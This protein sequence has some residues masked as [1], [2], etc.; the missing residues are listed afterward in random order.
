M[1]T[2]HKTKT[3]QRHWQRYTR[4]KTKT[5]QRHWQRYT[6][7]KTQDKQNTTQNR[8]LKR[9]ATRISP[10]TEGEQNVYNTAE[11][12]NYSVERK[13]ILIYK[14]LMKEGCEFW[15]I[16]IEYDFQGVKTKST[17]WIARDTNNYKLSSCHTLVLKKLQNNRNSYKSKRCRF[18]V[19]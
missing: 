2:R 6:R 4:H 10:K 14:L 8:K 13:Q 9:W 17:D 1:Y 15:A 5:I 18:S 12:K 7:H 16:F 19:L 11:T 3:I